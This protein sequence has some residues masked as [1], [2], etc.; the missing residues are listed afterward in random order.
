[1]TLLI[2]L[3]LISGVFALYE[4]QTFKWDWKQRY[5]GHVV[6][7]GF[8]I[9]PKASV[10]V[11][12]TESHVIAGLD[13]D[14]GV[15]LW[16][17]AQEKE[18]LGEVLDLHVGPKYSVSVSGEGGML[19]LRLWD[20]VTGAL[21]QEHLVR[22]SRK[23][24]LVSIQPGLLV[25]GY[26]DGGEI[27]VLTH[28]YD[29]KKLGEPEARVVKSP[30]PAT[31]GQGVQC[32]VS[33]DLVLV[34]SSSSSSLHLLDL[35][36]T[37]STWEIKDATNTVTEL[38]V[39]D[40][41]VEVET[42]IGMAR[43]DT[44]TGVLKTEKPGVDVSRIGGCGGVLVRQQ[45]KVEGRDAEGGKYCKDY[46]DVL[47]VESREGKVEHRLTEDRGRVERAWTGCEDGSWQ[48]VLL[49]EDGALLSLT[50]RGNLMFLREEAL[51]DISLVQMVA[52]GQVERYTQQPAAHTNMLDPALLLQ[53]FLARIKRHLNQLQGLV[54][55]VTDFRLSSDKDSVI[56]SDKFGLRKVVV[57]V[58]NR[59][60]LY[61]LDSGSGA[62][63]WQAR[64]PGKPS[65]LHLQRDGRTDNEAALACLV[66]R[67]SRSTHFI[68]AFNPITGVVSSES[69][70]N[71]ELDQALLLP[72]VA[73]FSL[74]PLLLVGKDSRAELFPSSAHS[75]LITL[76]RLFVVTDR[77]GQ[78]LVGNIVT[79]SSSGG[80]V[81][82]P[83][84]SLNSPGTNIIHVR[85]RQQDE[86]VH[87][88]GRVMDD[89]SVLF[90]YM[91]PNLALVVAEGQDTTS[92]SFITVQVVD[93][94]T[95]RI[96]FSATH[97][98]VAP[99]FHAV[100]S[101]NWAV[102]TYFNDKARRTELVS[103]ELYEGKTQG[104][105]TMF[106]SVE[107]TVVPLVER[108]AYILP[109]SDVVALT[110]TMTDKGITA[111]HLLVASS[112]GSILDLPLHMVDPRRPALN[113]PPHLREPGIPPY[114]PELPTPHESIL[115]YNQS[116]T[117]VRGI[118]A[119]PSGLE[120]TVLL[121]I[122]GLDL[123]GTRIAP[124]KGFDLI[125]DD[126]EHIM[127]AGVLLFLVAASFV[128]RKLAQ[129]KMLNRAWN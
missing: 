64:V 19:F 6:H 78:G 77:Q 41:T 83:V 100:L 71:L 25:L 47:E 104:N 49:M 60:K 14:S 75:H 68:L 92:K 106:S 40:T 107:N 118:T 86:K 34:C 8:H 112:Q 101:E 52:V 21:L 74:R 56:V 69:P 122:H 28:S 94:V 9:S 2:G 44:G 7:A 96:F 65:A 24:D 103:L 91:N 67:H 13:C 26:L 36:S 38:R 4:D 84:W 121:F 70:V 88:A 115:N 42:V 45:C 53:N 43:L 62:L 113:S 111:K 1:M 89:R 73:D 27:E 116:V 37:S 124:S 120:S 66:Y 15:I 81:L 76:P 105:N 57:V 3:L 82:T 51:A 102:Y 87:S 98:K 50:P 61:G 20:S 22:G 5:I 23:A 109:V 127:I 128:T 125:K 119:S 10:L 11:V 54:L 95:G 99:P 16:R 114:I 117:G 29:T 33:A 12:A 18:S 79:V 17:H 30:F 126:F 80:V 72:E 39:K 110:E 32:V 55:A 59:G 97:K 90:K 46:S 93:L 123:Y 35:G 48:L 63:L 31:L 58:S 108:Q 85:T 129:R